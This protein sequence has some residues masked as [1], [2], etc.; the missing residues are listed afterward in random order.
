MVG[1]NEMIPEY[2]VL[3][4]KGIGKYLKMVDNYEKYV[5]LAIYSGDYRIHVFENPFH[6]KESKSY[7]INCG[8]NLNL[9]EKM[10]KK[11]IENDLRIKQDI[12][13]KKF[14]RN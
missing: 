8:A 10:Y 1:E 3:E 14:S 6:T 12:I 2:K 7:M 11:I 4:Q 9:A 13:D 5:E